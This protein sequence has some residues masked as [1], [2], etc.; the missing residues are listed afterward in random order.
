[1]RSS[2]CLTGGNP[3][4]NLLM[5]QNT[6]SDADVAA[7]K[8]YLANKPRKRVRK[9]RVRDDRNQEKDRAAR[10]MTP[11]WGVW[12]ILLPMISKRARREDADI[13]AKIM[14]GT[15]IPD[16]ERIRR[17]TRKYADKTIVEAFADSYPDEV[18]VTNNTR[19]NTVPDQTLIPGMVVRVVIQSIGKDGVVI[20]P[21]NYK[22][23]FT[24]RNNLY[25]YK[26]INK[27]IIGS[28]ASAKVVSVNGGE[29]VV[30]IIAPMV[31]NFVVPRAN[32]PWIQ[33]LIYPDVI[34]PVKVCDLTLV[35]GGYIGKAIIPLASDILGEPYTIDAFIPGSQIELNTTNDFES[36]VGKT[37]N[38]FIQS[39][40]PRPR[41]GTMPLVC[42]RK[43]YLRHRGNMKMIQMFKDWCEKPDEFKKDHVYQGSVTGV[44]NSA[45]K[46]GVFVEIPSEGIT[47]L[48]PAQS[49]RLVDFKPGDEITVAITGFE[50]STYYDPASGQRVHNEPY[51][52]EDICLKKVNI[53]P[54]LEKV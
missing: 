30:D 9:E 20:D 16:K 6:V 49:S 1:M 45:N 10:L 53:K 46:C 44:I 33:N 38:T 5:Q 50:E 35:R 11:D 3:T 39:Y 40:S 43:A 32:K 31:D 54:I 37:V 21:G 28:T 48:I 41:T 14:H 26:N 29:A 2:I 27:E 42:S 22:V 19:A 18:T 12:K 25:K 23:N 15:Y 17:N 52:I 4:N 7:Q 34:T 36:Y 13:T 47:G 24:C 51:I 8:E